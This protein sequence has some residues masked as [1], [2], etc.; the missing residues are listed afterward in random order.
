MMKFILAAVLVLYAV[1][2]ILFETGILHFAFIVSP[3]RYVSY[4]IFGLCGFL[5]GAQK[6][7]NE[8]WLY[9]LYGEKKE[10]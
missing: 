5:F 4:F 7:K 2:V 8:E 3:W 6:E 9:Y 1:V 10:E